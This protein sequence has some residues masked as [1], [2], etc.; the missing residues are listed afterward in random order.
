MSKAII[1]LKF[2]T[3]DVRK[4][5]HTGDKIFWEQFAAKVHTNKKLKLIFKKERHELNMFDILRFCD[6]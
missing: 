5:S 2:E 3:V 1:N 4:A 6:G